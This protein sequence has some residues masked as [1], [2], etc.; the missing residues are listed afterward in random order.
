MFQIAVH[1]VRNG[2]D[3]AF[4]LRCCASEMELA[5]I[6]FNGVA[7]YVI[8]HALIERVVVVDAVIYAAVVHFGFVWKNEERHEAYQFAIEIVAEDLV[9]IRG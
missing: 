3:S 6:V 1:R 8:E 5:E 4:D 7:H 2:A 9:D